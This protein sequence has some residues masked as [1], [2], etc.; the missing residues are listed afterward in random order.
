MILHIDL[1][2]LDCRSLKFWVVH[3]LI[4][5]REKITQANSC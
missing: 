2:F 5:F 4:K 3:K 1:V